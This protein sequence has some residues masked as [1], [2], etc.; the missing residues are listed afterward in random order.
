MGFYVK[1]TWRMETVEGHLHGTPCRFVN[2]RVDLMAVIFCGHCWNGS[3]LEFA[4]EYTL[5]I[6]NVLSS[7]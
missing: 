7:D 6:W 4:Q 1:E 3:E 2:L 5:Y